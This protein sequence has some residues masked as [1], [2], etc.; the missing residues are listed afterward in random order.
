M[1][2]ISHAWWNERLVN[3]AQLLSIEKRFAR[4]LNL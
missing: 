4:S 1:T 2:A 3:E